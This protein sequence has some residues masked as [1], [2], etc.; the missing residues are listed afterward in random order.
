MT[1][2]LPERVTAGVPRHLCA[3]NPPKLPRKTLTSYGRNHLLQTRVCTLSATGRRVTIS[4]D[5]GEGRLS[6]LTAVSEPP[7]VKDHGFQPAPAPWAGRSP[8]GIWGGGRVRT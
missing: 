1:F 7:P 3:E 6:H 2:T 5:L 4:D 8:A